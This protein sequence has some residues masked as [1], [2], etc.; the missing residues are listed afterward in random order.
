MEKLLQRLDG[1]I[2]HNTTTLDDFFFEKG[3]Q[4]SLESSTEEQMHCK[5][6]KLSGCGRI[7][8]MR[9]KLVVLYVRLFQMGRVLD[10]VKRKLK[11]ESADVNKIIRYIDGNTYSSMQWERFTEHFEKVHPDFFER[12]QQHANDLTEHEMRICA[13][14]RMRMDNKAI[15]GVLCISP[16]GFETARYRLKKKLGLSVVEDLNDFIQKV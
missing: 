3:V 9:R 4:G 10:E 6:M 1:L 12:L 11:G 14:L 7:N 8:K 16:R 2:D 13:Y 15:T 5:T